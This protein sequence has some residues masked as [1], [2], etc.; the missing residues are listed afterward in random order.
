[1][2]QTPPRR[3]PPTKQEPSPTRHRTQHLGK[4]VC[5]ISP[6]IQVRLQNLV[7]LNRHS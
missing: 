1:M 6:K 3:N 2:S 5:Q 4:A 7:L